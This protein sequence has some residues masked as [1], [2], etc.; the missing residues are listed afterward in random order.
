M[1]DAD[2]I[3]LAIITYSRVITLENETTENGGGI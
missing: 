1:Y 3:A 2:T